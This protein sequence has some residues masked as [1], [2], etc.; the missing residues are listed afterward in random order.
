ME[1]ISYVIWKPAGASNSDFR[2]E[3]VGPTAKQILANGAHKLSV[4]C[5]DETTEALEKARITQVE[6]PHCGMISAWVDMSDDVAAIE[7]AIDRVTER[8][9]GDRK[10]VV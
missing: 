5:P 6:D 1:K 4:V 3:L 7:E 8:K 10:S 9:A 2:D